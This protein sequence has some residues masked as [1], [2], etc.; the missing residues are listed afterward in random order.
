M[1]MLPC[2]FALFVLLS[3]ALFARSSW[4][5]SAND[6]NCDFPIENL[7]YGIF[8]QVESQDPRIGVAIGDYVLDVTG[9]VEKELLPVSEGVKKA[10]SQQTLNGL[11]ALG[12]DSWH[13][14][15]VAL[16]HLLDA[17][18]CIL[19]DDAILQRSL[20]IARASVQMHL[21]V[22]IGDYTDYY[23]SVHHASNVGSLF[24]P[25]TPSLPPN[26]KHMPLGYH[27]RASS[28][29]VSGTEI[30]R[31]SGQIKRDEAS[32]PSHEPTDRLDYEMELAAFVGPGNI[33]GSPIPIDRASRHLF[34]AVILNDWSA[35]DIQKWEYTPLGPINS[36]NF[37]T[38]VSP[39]V[40]SFEALEPYRISNFPHDGEPDIL[41]YL[42]TPSA[43]A[44]SIVVEV[45]LSSSIMRE[46]GLEPVLISRG[47]FSSQYW[48]FEQMLAQHTSTGCNMRPG[49]LIGS[50]TISGPTR[51]SRGCLVEFQLPDGDPIRLS[52]GSTR[53][54]L[55]DGDEVIMKAYAKGQGLPRIG[56]GECRGLVLPAR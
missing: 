55:V 17:D 39:W 36:K 1:H 47:N 42:R 8:S 41:P 26:F 11:L 16:M 32:A 2:L 13:G 19:R 34:G 50:G 15:R 12:P 30:R 4:V 22:A 9:C 45:Y 7:P 51:D 5:E 10:L 28:V 48:T 31:P 49:D 46:L 21:P 56:F 38:T 14:L 27:G 6:P 44:Y 20:L 24:R 37:A 25:G 29:V 3:P 54:F 23:T 43:A 40:V 33:L 18:T 52:D 35:R 53:Q